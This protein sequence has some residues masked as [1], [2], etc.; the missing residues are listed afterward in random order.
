MKTTKA[1]RPSGIV[2]EM[3]KAS[4]NTSVWLVAYLANDMIRNGIIRSDWENSFIIN[5]YKGK[6]DALIR[7]N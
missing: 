4:G 5:I 6:G 1:A 2:A 7:G 3:L